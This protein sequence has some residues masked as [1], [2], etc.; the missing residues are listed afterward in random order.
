MSRSAA[1]S[2]AVPLETAEVSTVA[3]QKQPGAAPSPLLVPTLTIVSHPMPT[4]AGERLLLQRLSAGRELALSR[5]AP[6]FTRPESPFGLP[7]GDPYISRKPLL[8]EQVGERVR[9]TAAEEGKLLY[10]GE[11]LRGSREFSAEEL[12]EGVPLVLAGRV[13]LLLHLSSPEAGE[14]LDSM[15]MVGESAGV[16]RIRKHIARVADLEVPVLIRGAT[17]TGKELVAQALHQRSQRRGRFVSV[18]LGAI[19]KELAAAE[20]FGTARGAYTGATRDRDGFFR[21][22]EG[23]TLFLDE[24]GEAPPEVQVMLLR[25]LETGEMYPVGAS[26]PVATN[27]RLV[28]ATDANLEARIREGHFKA[29][30]LHRL[31]GYEVQLP[32]LRERREDLGRLF[33]HFAREAL[34]SLGEAHRLSPGD[35]YV[36]PWLPAALA[37]RLLLHPWP[38]N[39]RQ[40][41]NVA[42]QL[43]I[44]SRGQPCLEVE[45][46]LDQELGETPPPTPRPSE[47]PSTQAVRAPA[48]RKST[49][50]TEPVLLAALRENAWDVKRAADSL[51]VPRSS[52]YDFIERSPNIRLAGDLSVEELTQCFH[53]CQGNLDAMVR[54]LEVS[55][56]A[57]NRRVKELGLVPRES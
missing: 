35:P 9:I 56:S 51:G 36:A 41:R 45:P 2:P 39:I 26:T 17:G 10:A 49:E 13:V 30:L 11:P 46:R 27:V 4:R 19:P 21:A 18:N 1:R 54:R 6:E 15:G 55:K 7:L 25:V 50:L 53:E 23:G 48:R 3:E 47:A 31:A 32:P 57:L 29:P 14:P 52:I 44:G 40:L 43:V 37:V 20:L 22:A 38:G 42:R 34:E 24:V 8:F 28:A 5:N 16:R 12:A 33:L